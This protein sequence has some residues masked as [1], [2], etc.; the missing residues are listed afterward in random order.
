LTTREVDI[1]GLLGGN[2]S[3]KEIA[4]SLGIS[5][6][7]VDHHVSAILTKLGASTRKDAAAHAATGAL[8]ANIGNRKAKHRESLPM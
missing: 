4:A 2:M 6:K 5:P 3:N 1:L 8:L 7:T